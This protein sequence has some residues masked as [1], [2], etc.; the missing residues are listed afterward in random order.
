MTLID[1]DGLE[2]YVFGRFSSP[3]DVLQRVERLPHYAVEHQT[4]EQ[5]AWERPDGQPD[6]PGKQPWFDVLA[7]WQADGM[8]VQRARILSAE[9]TPDERRTCNWDYPY[10]GRWEQIRVLHRGEH[11]I[12]DVVEHD[13]WIIRPA[14]GPVAVVAMHYSPSGEF[15]GARPVEGIEQA[16]YL[17]EWALAWAIGEP[18]DTWWARHGELHRRRAA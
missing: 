16:P 5:A 13:Y 18:F 15:I 1:E 9:L 11:P 7:G 10:T 4:A 8:T 12:P 2:S 17:R 14:A 6:L 3:G